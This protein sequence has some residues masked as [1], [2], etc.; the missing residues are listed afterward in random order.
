MIHDRVRFN[1]GSWTAML[2]KA[3]EKYN[4]NVHSS[5][6][7]TPRGAHDDKNHMD[8]RVNLTRR[9]KNA[10]RYLEVKVNNM[11]KVFEKGKDNYTVRKEYNSKWE[12]I[13]FFVQVYYGVA[14]KQRMYIMPSGAVNLTEL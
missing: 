13:H 4:G 8:V 11:V 1:K 10:C 3:L 14:S 5:T 12:N 2:S 9:E 6:K 7:M